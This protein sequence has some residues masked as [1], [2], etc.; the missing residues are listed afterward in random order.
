MVSL[1]FQEGGLCLLSLCV[2]SVGR[3]VLVHNSR[4]S[5]TDQLSC[6][7]ELNVAV[8]KEAGSH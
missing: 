3:M 4:E 1:Y 7:V 6:S 8:T 2:M 5:L